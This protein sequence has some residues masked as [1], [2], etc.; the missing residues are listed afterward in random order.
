MNAARITLLCLLLATL[1]GCFSL[2]GDKRPVAIY[3][4]GD[5][6]ASSATTHTRNTA[7]AVEMPAASG[8][9]DSP[10]LLVSPVAGELRVYAGARW[11]ERPAGLLRQRLLTALGNAGLGHAMPAE[12]GALAPYMLE[13]D[14]DSFHARVGKGAAT[15]SVVLQVRLIDSASRQ[16]LA[17]RRFQVE[18]AAA[19]DHAAALADAFGRASN[20][21]A[22][23]VARW[24]VATLPDD[25]GASVASP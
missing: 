6:P 23:Q 15:V 4:L 9:L 22:E 3:T 2:G 1:T 19:S 16:L 10:A 21:L 24:T 7:L 20:R 8:M 13:S 11:A 18:Q 25:A 5:A 14:L 17:Q 12:S